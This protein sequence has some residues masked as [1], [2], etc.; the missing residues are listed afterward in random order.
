MDVII[1]SVST[2]NKNYVVLDSL[3]YAIKLKRYVSEDCRQLQEL[4]N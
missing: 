4:L 1:I 2:E 3:L